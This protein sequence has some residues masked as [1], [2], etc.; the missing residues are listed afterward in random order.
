M[1]QATTTGR[2]YSPRA[3]PSLG[4]LL[5]G[6]ALLVLALF[7]V[8]LAVGRA[9]LPVQQALDDVLH[10]RTTLAS[11]VLLEIRL[12]RAL[13]GLLVG[14]SLGLAGAAMQGL[15][16]NPLAEP[17]VVGV[18]GCAA[19]G[20][21]L[22]FYTGLSV[23]VPLALP[24]GG[25][26]GALLAVA[27]LALLT[28]RQ[29]STLTLILAGVALNSLA[30]ALTALALNLA[31]N[32]SLGTLLATAGKALTALALNLAPNPYAAVEIIFWLMGSLADRSLHHVILVLPL[33]LGGWGL[34]LHTAQALDGLTL[35]EDTARSLGVRLGRLQLQLVVG[36]ALAVGSAV[37]VTG[38]I[39]FVGLVVPH[40][41]RP[42]VGYQPSQLLLTSALGG[43]ALILAAD[44]AVR[45]LAVGPELKLGVVT[46]LL[47]A[48]FFLAL[49]HRLRRETL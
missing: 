41:L 2:V 18:S 6:L 47:G 46:A 7:V 19:F 10:G 32:L 25:I 43:A 28:G 36:T 30:G 49:L 27:L 3:M 20:A 31:P 17:G 23:T 45:L 14:M 35:G 5:T 40:L 42:L 8:S 11:L 33:M 37:A 44:I 21:V 16:R 34:L 24:L 39:G 22:A 13:L 38:T 12:P 48:P 15:L 26:A 29:A 1:T 9:P 4:W